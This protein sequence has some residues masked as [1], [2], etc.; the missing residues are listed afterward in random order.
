[1]C[2]PMKDTKPPMYSLAEES[3]LRLMRPLDLSANL[4]EILERN[5]LQTSMQL[6]KCRL[7]ETLQVQHPG[8]IDQCFSTFFSCHAPKEPF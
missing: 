2:C 5:L 3:K 6:A 8:F 1:M 4:K 7:R